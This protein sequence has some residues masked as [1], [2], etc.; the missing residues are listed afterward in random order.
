MRFETQPGGWHSNGP[1]LMLCIARSRSE[2]LLPFDSF[3]DVSYS[4]H[5]S[6]GQ[7]ELNQIFAFGDG[8]PFGFFFFSGG[9]LWGRE[10]NVRGRG[11]PT[12]LPVA[13]AIDIA[14][15]VVFGF[16]IDASPCFKYISLYAAKTSAT[17]P[18][19]LLPFG[20]VLSCADAASSCGSKP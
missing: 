6:F 14:S 10:L 5:L 7:R 11:V 1:R 19:N 18:V 17:P 4:P 16:I 20:G 12:S 2:V 13:T 8:F 9:V 3:H 15:G